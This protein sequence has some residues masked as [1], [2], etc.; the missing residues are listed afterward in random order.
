MKSQE[1][2]FVDDPEIDPKIFKALQKQLE[3]AML[4]ADIVPTARSTMKDFV[5]EITAW[6]SADNVLSLSQRAR[7]RS[8][9]AAKIC[10]VRS[11]FPH[12]HVL[13][14]SS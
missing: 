2:Y 11:E 14:S 12:G 13:T 8:S 9:F 1:T 5:A 6:A 4:A 3:D 7:K 10:A